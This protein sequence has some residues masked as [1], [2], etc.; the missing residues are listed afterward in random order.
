MNKRP[1]EI[2]VDLKQVLKDEA[3]WEHADFGIVAHF[4]AGLGKKRNGVVRVMVPEPESSKGEEKLKP[5]NWNKED[6]NSNPT[7]PSEEKK[8]FS[9][10]HC[11]FE[12]DYNSEIYAHTQ[13]N[14]GSTTPPDAWETSQDYKQAIF[15]ANKALDNPHIDPDG[16]ISTIARQFLRMIER[17]AVLKEKL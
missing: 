2:L 4:V 7:P 12:T 8:R 1:N 6:T 15:A 11:T 17:Y 14:H 10:D 3:N 13:M 5:T 16:D 9:C